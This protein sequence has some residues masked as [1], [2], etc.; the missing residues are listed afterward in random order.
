MS[1]KVLLVEDN[2]DN[3]K[4]ITWILEDGD[5]EIVVA[6]SGERALEVIGLQ[7][8]DI[9]LMDVGLPGISGEETTRQLRDMEEYKK[10]PIIA[11]TAHALKTE[12]DRIMSAG[13]NALVTKPVDETK[14][15]TLMNS[16]ID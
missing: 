7:S 15:L 16:L 2:P 1:T 5:Y 14:L 4:L 3:R 6:E 12:V 9:V 11:V 13:F 10:V 8:I